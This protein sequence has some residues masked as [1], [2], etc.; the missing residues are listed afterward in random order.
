MF[1]YIWIH[2]DEYE[3]VDFETIVFSWNRY[4]MKIA[5]SDVNS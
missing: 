2:L 1:E 3:R 5:Q 4:Q